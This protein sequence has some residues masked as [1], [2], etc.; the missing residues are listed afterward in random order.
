[1]LNLFKLAHIIFTDFASDISK[2]EL[3][4]F[5]E[6]SDAYTHTHNLNKAMLL[7]NEE[8]QKRMGKNERKCDKFSENRSF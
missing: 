7:Y 2:W 8:D 6:Q 3:L 5:N 4:V 1:M